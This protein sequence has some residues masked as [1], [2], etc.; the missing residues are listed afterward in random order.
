MEQRLSSWKLLLT[1]KAVVGSI[2]QPAVHFKENSLRH[3]SLCSSSV[4]LPPSLSKK[5]YKCFTSVFNLVDM[6][7]FSHYTPF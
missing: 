5:N 3:S 6:V 1:L 7:I 2:H 4:L